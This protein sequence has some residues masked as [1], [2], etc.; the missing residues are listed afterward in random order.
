VDTGLVHLAAAFGTPAVGIYCA[1]DPQLTGIHGCARSA[2]LGGPSRPPAPQ[3]VFDA[4]RACGA[5]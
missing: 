4:L 3:H 5:L 1:T 2:N